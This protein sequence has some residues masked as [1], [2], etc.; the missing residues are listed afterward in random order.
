MSLDE[1]PSSPA[2][3][4]NSLAASQE[5]GTF[6][7]C[8]CGEFNPGDYDTCH[9]CQ[10]GQP[11]SDPRPREGDAFIPTS[12]DMVGEFV[13]VLVAFTAEGEGAVALTGRK[14]LALAAIDTCFRTVCGQ[15]NLLDDPA[16][17]LMDAY[18]YL[19][20]GH[21]VFTR[22]A[23]GGWDA[24]PAPSEAT[25]AVPVTWFSGG[26]TGPIPDPYAPAGESALW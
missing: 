4:W 6:W 2:S 9:F 15:P 5:A 24:V 7:K 17:P 18:F 25:H 23:D 19:D 10:G 14:D 26:A 8:R 21:A 1:E 13:G 16:R 11:A 22:C 20:S 3:Y 12:S